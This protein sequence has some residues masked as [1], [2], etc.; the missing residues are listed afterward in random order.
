MKIKNKHLNL[1]FYEKKR[2]EKKQQTFKKVIFL[3]GISL[4][5]W[6][7]NKEVSIE[8]L[9]GELNVL[10]TK[11][12][13]IIG[14]D[15]PEI[16][17]VLTAYTGKISSKKAIYSK[18]LSYKKA[19]I[20]IESILK[21][22]DYNSIVNYTFNIIIDD[23]P[24]NEF[25]NLVINEQPNGELK[26]PYVTKYVVDNDA[27]ANYLANNKDFRYFKGKNYTM[28]F[29]SFFD[30]YDTSG[31]S[32]SDCPPDE[33]T[34]NNTNTGGNGNFNDI[35]SDNFIQVD[36]SNFNYSTS[37]IQGQSFEVFLNSF[38][39]TTLETT[40]YS[41]IIMN[42]A[43]P[44]TTTAQPINPI[45]VNTNLGIV[46]NSGPVVIG[47]SI[48]TVDNSLNSGV[49]S[50]CYMTI[51]TY[52]S[53]G[54]S[55]T[56]QTDIGC[57]YAPIL[58]KPAFSSKTTTCPDPAE[59]EIGVI[60][61]ACEYPYVKDAQGNCV[62][63]DKIINNLTNSC[64]KDIF[65]ELENGIFTTHPLKPEIIIS[66][67]N[68]LELNFSETILKLFNDSSST[69]LI[70]GN[71]DIGNANAHTVGTTITLNNSYI[72][73]ATQLSIARTIIHE[74]VH[75]YLNGVYFSYTDFE[76]K[77]LQEKMRQY[78]ADNGYTDYSKFQHEFMGQY[79]NAMAYSLYE[80]DKDYGTGGNLG[81]NYYYSMGFGGLF[82]TYS[83][84]IIASETDS[85]KSLIPDSIERQK[86]ANIIFN[87]L[88]NNDDA[89]GKKCN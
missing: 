84:G 70:I 86:I 65:M 87:E 8:P 14:K 2:K 38:N 23:A 32:L 19:R 53:D 80:W 36:A 30:N 82:Q 83:N 56:S 6:N 7:C 62:A 13:Y 50:G 27:L 43:I 81:W 37:V 88:K 35:P 24:E 60:I 39:T 48:T 76:N 22:K 12:G 3:L 67:N 33:T 71:D 79:V 47:M 34:I 31:K 68:T 5:L 58:T 51:V 18:T 4:L 55:T 10:G 73:T 40:S 41:A 89:K 46:T 11:I 57:M 52:Y 77:S 75:A 29:N 26:L 28:S 42:T 61:R 1:N 74:S 44:I 78:A 66:N 45:T 20:D 49:N 9:N 54:T 64:A 69:H 25:Y 63:P 85:F 72:E 21:V 17:N 59:G 16:I 15:I